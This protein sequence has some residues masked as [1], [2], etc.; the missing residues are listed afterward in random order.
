M[1]KSL[2]LIRSDKIAAYKNLANLYEWR[3]GKAY[4]IIDRVSFKGKN[5][6]ILCYY[7][8][9]V[10]QVGNQELDAY[11]EGLSRVIDNKDN[12]NFLILCGANDPV[13]AG[14]DLRESLSNIDKTLEMK[15]EK[16]ERG[17]RAD[18]IDRLFDWADNRLKKGIALHRSIR[19]LSG[20]VRVVAIC[21]GGTRFGG[22]AEI[23]LMADFLVGDSR[24]GI[25]FSEAM[26][27]LIPGW[28]GIVRILIK[29]GPHNAAYM[30]KSGKEIKA[31]KL[32]EIGVYN[33]VVEISSGFPR[34]EDT[35]NQE[36]DKANHRE[37]LDIHNE[38]TGLLLIPK[39]LEL[40]TR[41][42]KEIPRV[43]D[44]DR[45]NLGENEDI[46]VEVARRATPGNY[47]HLWGKPL[48]EVQ[49]EIDNLGRPLAP[50]SIEALNELLEGCDPSR[51]DEY[52]FAKKEMGADARL[53]RDSRYRAGVVATLSQTVAD[54]RLL[55]GS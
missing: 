22:S 33:E 7:N 44:M 34:R 23:P 16:E 32:K 2:R 45:A 10:H 37:A 6:A 29:S 39:G 3:D 18:E 26:I 24:S 17:A 38:E 30:A 27:G 1:E 20:L 13:H 46:S 47:A 31:N 5:G 49:E 52:A 53:Y 36:L 19:E 41:P 9:P 21:G 40:A 43:D 50:Q 14:G 8:P 48:R 42:L 55:E 28:A 35:G 54:F 11:L 12:I 25:C 51:L 4:L 15:R